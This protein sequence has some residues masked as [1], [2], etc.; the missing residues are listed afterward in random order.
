MPYQ[1]HQSQLIGSIGSI[2]FPGRSSFLL[3]L[4]LLFS[5]QRERRKK[6]FL[7]FAG[8]FPYTFETFSHTHTHDC[9][10]GPKRSWTSEEI[11]Q[12][13]L[14]VIG[15]LNI[16]TL[17]SPSAKPSPIV[18]CLYAPKTLEARYLLVPWTHTH[19]SHK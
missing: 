13:I 11:F 3:L 18:Y 7:S 10:G 19:T 14:L 1:A 16:D 17:I 4:L 8:L 5:F 2:S 9:F 12:L 15:G 6:S